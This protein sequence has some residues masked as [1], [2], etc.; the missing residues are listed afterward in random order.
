VS[1]VIYR[2]ATS[3]NGFIA[4][5][6]HSLDWLFAVDHA[7]VPAHADFL[8][9]IG[10]IVKG[11][12][13]YEWVLRQT[14]VLTNPAQW[15][16]FYGSRPTFVFTSRQLEVPAGADVR[17]VN[18]PVT[19]ALPAIADAAGGQD[20]W[21]VGGGDLAGQFC[22]AGALDR[23]EVTLAPVSLARG[24]P[25]LPRRLE[26][27]RLSL[28]SIERYGQFAHLVYLVSHPAA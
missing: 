20:I 7:D 19:A 1:E 22:D 16:E 8:A 27:D 15:A 26:S 18:G 6:Q 4:D 2:T 11:S 10:V 12:T 14:D 24:A 23:I 3:F 25:L 9:Q 17:F 28:A 13:T 5:E 21:L